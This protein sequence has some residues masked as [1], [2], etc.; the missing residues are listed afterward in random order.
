[1]KWK[2]YAILIASYTN[3]TEEDEPPKTWGLVYLDLK[4]KCL[5]HK[6]QI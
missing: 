5:V 1:M 4:K 6:V 3:I 2:S